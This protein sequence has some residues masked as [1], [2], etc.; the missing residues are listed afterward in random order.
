MSALLWPLC[1]FAAFALGNVAYL[2][3]SVWD[4]CTK[5]LPRGRG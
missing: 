4:D 1:A 3:W 2:G 5:P